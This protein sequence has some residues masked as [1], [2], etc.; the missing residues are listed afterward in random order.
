MLR[1]RKSAFFAWLI[2]ALTIVTALADVAFILIQ[3]TGQEDQYANIIFALVPILFAIPAALIITRQPGNTIGW[4]LMINPLV[5]IPSSL[6]SIYLSG[7]Q[8]APPPPTFPN[9]FMIWFVSLS[10]M[11]LIFPVL[12]IPLFFP[13]GRLISPR[14]RWTVFLTIGMTLFLS[15]WGAFT[16]QIY[17]DFMPWEMTNPIGFITEETTN[18]ILAPWSIL[19]AV[20]TIASLASMVVRYRRG[21][22]VE[23]QQMKWLL[24]ACFL[25]GLVYIPGVITNTNSSK[26]SVQLLIGYLLPLAIMAI[27]ASITIAILRYRLF[28]IDV[29]IRLTLVYGLLTGLLGL[30][31]FGGVVV[32]QQVFR[33]LSGQTGQVAI[34]ITTLLMAALFN[35]L[36]RRIQSIIDRRFFR[37]KYNADQALA[38]FAV[39]ARDSTVPAALTTML[40]DITRETL[41]P[42]QVSLFLVKKP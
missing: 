11:A 23:R 20:V 30:V 28:D 27:P 22:L 13:N 29:I 1:M 6:F 2:C 15:V 14:W 21:S 40:L 33:T 8:T 18:T 36:R 41:E 25:F 37:Q 35:P 4:L 42:T 10:W 34:V 38:R 5:E 31:Y 16:R 9:L 12:L 7:F 17:L 39:A 24:Y 19:L 26:W 32:L 3:N